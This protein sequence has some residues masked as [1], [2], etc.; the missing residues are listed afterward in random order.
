[1]KNNFGFFMPAEIVKSKDKDGVEKMQIA[2][3]ASTTDE[4]TDEEILLPKGFDLSYFTESGFVNWHHRQKDKP[5]AIIG[6]PSAAKVID[7]GKKMHVVCDLYDTPLAQEVFALGK[8]LESQSTSGRRL[9][10]S[11]EGKVL[12]RDKNNPRI[13]TKAAITGCA[14]TYQPKN[15]ATIA[16]I[17]KADGS[18]P[19][20]DLTPDMDGLLEDLKLMKAAGASSK[21]ILKACSSDLDAQSFEGEIKKVEGDEDEEKEGAD[22][23]EK[24]I[25]GKYTS[26]YIKNG[27]W[28][29]VYEHPKR[30][31]KLRE[32]DAEIRFHKRQR[33]T[34]ESDQEN[35]QDVID[36]KEDGNHPSVAHH[37][38]ILAKIDKKIA[39]LHKRKTKY[40]DKHVEGEFV[41]KQLFD[42]WQQLGG[43]IEKTLDAGSASGQ[44]IAPS[45]VDDKLKDNR[46]GFLSKASIEGFLIMSGIEVP[47]DDFINFVLKVKNHDA[48]A[49]LNS[50]AD[51]ITKADMDAALGLLEKAKAYKADQP[52][53]LDPEEDDDE[54]EKEGDGDND[55]DEVEKGF[56][57]ELGSATIP[58]MTIEKAVRELATNYSAGFG[59]VETL[60]KGFQSELEKSREETALLRNKLEEFE[61]APAVGRKALT[62]LSPAQPIEKAFDLADADNGISKAGNVKQLSVSRQKA[63]ICTELEKLAF[64]ANG[65]NEPMAKAMTTFESSSQL[66][67]TAVEQLRKQG[68]EIIA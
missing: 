20:V 37:G 64:P 48:M 38:K 44:A 11:I 41:P 9:G 3:I 34:A 21:E 49:N 67:P 31:Q 6:E 18:T 4:D 22:E 5:S 58:N 42:A 14:I 46:P 27:K 66:D 12:E 50:N 62:R 33:A 56:N 32:I 36:N 26:K 51:T 53:E 60:L 68:F 43:K 1:M 57:D 47:T 25:G 63:A 23:V 16:E 15:K 13:V 40:A 8:V 19:D 17:V 2:G 65:F 45:S 39:S 35:D 7:G 55:G 52:D 59:A 29:Y 30:E 24:A 54:K 61:S 10:F 28:V